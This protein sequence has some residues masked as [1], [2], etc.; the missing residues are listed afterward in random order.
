MLGNKSMK[1][2]RYAEQSYQRPP[3]DGIALDPTPEEK[4]EAK[5]KRKAVKQA[6]KANRR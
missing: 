5:R 2:A 3:A 1:N 4:A 6:R